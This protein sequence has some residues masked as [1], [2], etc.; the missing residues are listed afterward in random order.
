MT[1]AVTLNT[2]QRLFSEMLDN[3]AADDP[4]IAILEKNSRIPG[5]LATSQG[6]HPR[7][8]QL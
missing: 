2:S 8:V 5:Q 4:F 3:P 6:L 1:N 7:K